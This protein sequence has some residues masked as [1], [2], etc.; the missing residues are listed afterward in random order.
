MMRKK[1]IAVISE[2]AARYKTAL[3]R[4]FDVVLLPADRKLS[5]PVASHPDMILCRVGE[6]LAVPREYYCNNSELIDNLIDRTCLALLLSDAFREEVY[7]HDI[8]MNMLLCG[9]FAFALAEYTAKEVKSSL[10]EQGIQLI[11]MK[12]GYA[13]CTSLSAGGAIITAD[14]SAAA[15]A[16]S[17]NIDVT[18]I[19]DGDIR[20]PGYD[21]GFIGG[22]S[23][24]CTDSVY[25]F[26]NLDSHSDGKKIRDALTRRGFKIISLSDE[27]LTDFGGIL[28]LE[29]KRGF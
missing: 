19:S 24:V 21:T 17:A 2:S 5:Q 8:A 22:A 11:N 10:N 13:A 9:K 6:T 15:A 23:G 29:N 28:F 18:V 20:L 3:E 27:T 16:K 26:G 7:P 1:Y 25:F 14:P 4:E 12:Q